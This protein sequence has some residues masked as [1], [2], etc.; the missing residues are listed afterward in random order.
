MRHDLQEAWRFLRA[1]RGFA[2]VVVLTLGLA[3]GVNSTIFSILNGV[4]L[5]PL[6]YAEPDRLVVAWESN[7]T[8]GQNQSQVSSATY[9]DWRTQSTTFDSMAAWRYKGFTL[10]T[11]SEAERVT[12]VDI[13]PLMFQVLGISPVLGR[14]F[15]PGEEQPGA[16]KSV[17]LSHA[18]WSK[19][20]GQDPSVLGRMLTLDDE[21]YEIVG[22]MPRTFQFPAGDAEVELWAPLTMSAA[23]AGSR[24]HRTYNTI[25]RLRAGVTLEQA[26]ADLDRVAETI[27]ADYPDT[28]A[29]WGV[30]LVPAHEQV[31]GDIGNTLWV[32][33]GA[34]VLVLI[35]A[36]VNIANL[37]LAR[38][39]RT[40]KEFAVRAAIGASQWALLRRSLVES[41]SLAAL[42]GLAGVLL[43]WWGIGAIRPLI[44]A[45][46]PRADGI[47]L[48]LP[49]LAFTATTAIVAALIF[50]LFPA[51]RAMRPQLSEVFQDSSRGASASRSTRRLSD[52]MVT[53]EVALA[54]MLLVGAGLLIR[55][56]VQ[57][58]S[59]DPGYKTSG[60]V[61]AHIVLPVSRYGP[62]ASKKQ[63]FDDLVSRV[64]TLPGVDAASA[65]S[66]LPMSPLGVQF[67]LPFTIDGLAETS[68]SERPRARYRAVM[69]DYFSTM[70]I[71]LVDGR[72][73]DDFDGRENGPQVAIVNELVVRRYFQGV[74]PLDKLVR[75]PM[76][77][78]LR[79]VGVV[80]DIKHDGLASSAEPEVFVPY[81]QFA[82]SEMQVVMAT[83]LPASTVAREVRSQMQQIDSSLPIAR[84]TTIEERVSSSIA[85]PR[86]NMTLLASLAIC[87]ALLAALGVYG[88]V[89]YAVARRT[90]EIGIRMALGADAGGTFWLVVIGA[91][92]VVLL[93]V[94]L[95][96]AGAALMG[97]SIESLLFGVPTLD[98]WTYVVASVGTVAIGMLAA[99]LPAMRATRIDP[100]S[101][102]RQD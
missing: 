41:G 29:G 81:F 71:D 13:S 74:S 1:N 61:A 54:L 98:A 20:F 94:A 46:V 66:A 85:Q 10:R 72:T 65:V 44:P 21:S 4:L 62:S 83:A 80:S 89:T 7:Q 55:S 48:D 27:A 84:I 57:L 34:V 36:C 11:D 99:M 56:F 6:D 90:T 22:V 96:L 63:F 70:G 16:A 9:L 97:T 28:N 59:I 31:V 58:T 82:L 26:Q 17:I 64:K 18:S 39:S 33:F 60:I 93:G 47:G 95:G 53:A 14:A 73:F 88:V 87:A 101:A 100:V 75:I 86:F 68:P 38:S 51:W 3:I 67:E 91:A 2:T 42:G 40:A 49:V 52:W 25:G 12:T 15:T 30:R 76:A 102:L 24:P 79:I 5:R 77:G 19:R 32:L 92:R 43:A 69:A 23:S 37:L 35:I 45:N 50:G 8:L 78:D